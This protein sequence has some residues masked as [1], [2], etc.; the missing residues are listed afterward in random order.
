MRAGEE[1]VPEKES[2]TTTNEE[3]PIIGQVRDEWAAELLVTKEMGEGEHNASVGEIDRHIVM[4]EGDLEGDQKRR[5]KRKPNQIIE[6]QVGVKKR[7]SLEKEEEKDRNLTTMG[8]V[9]I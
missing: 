8:D 1:T 2:T 6:S 7:Y 9:G 4:E 3:E 5:R